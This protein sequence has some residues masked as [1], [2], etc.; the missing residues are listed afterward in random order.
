MFEKS[1]ESINTEKD[2]EKVC[3]IKFINNC[4]EINTRNLKGYYESKILSFLIN[5]HNGTRPIYFSRHGESVYNTKGW[6]GGDSDLSP[7]GELYGVALGTFFKYEAEKYFSGFPNKP[8]LYC[9][10]LKRTNQTAKNLLF[11]NNAI[12]LKNLDEINVGVCDGITYKEFEE[13]YPEE[14]DLRKKDKLR[15]RYPRGESYL[16]MI[17][18]IEQVIY[19]LE[20]Q[21]GPAIVIGHQGILRALYGYFASI[22]A[23]KIPELEIPLH[24]VIKFTPH[25]YGFSEQRILIDPHTH[26]WEIVN[27]DKNTVDSLFDKSREINLIYKENK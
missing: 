11:I 13:K 18:R 15:Y 20:R 21:D 27:M 3:F 6:I 7:E 1:Y 26:K 2:G 25:A 12:P 14:H 8:K 9:S 4:Q 5:I 22:P 19:E 10:T 24:T 16:D 23:E 17:Q